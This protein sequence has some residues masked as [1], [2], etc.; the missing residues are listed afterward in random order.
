MT[1]FR[2][3]SILFIFIFV[4]PFLLRLVLRFLFGSPEPTNHSSQQRKKVSSSRARSAEKRK[5]ISED[6][7][8]YIDYEE[9]KD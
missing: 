1:I 6:E 2:I 3:L 4:V 8:E 7:G 9:I 5:V